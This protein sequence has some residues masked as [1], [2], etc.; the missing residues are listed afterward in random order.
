MF[1][2][3]ESKKV[4]INWMRKSSA[5]LEL[6]LDFLNFVFENC[7]LTGSVLSLQPF[8]NPSPLSTL[9]CFIS[10]VS[11]GAKQISWGKTLYWCLLVLRI[12]IFCHWDTHGSFSCPGLAYHCHKTV[13]IN[14]KCSTEYFR[15]KLNSGDEIKSVMQ[16]LFTWSVLHVLDVLLCSEILHNIIVLDDIYTF[17]FCSSQHIMRVDMQLLPSIRRV[18]IQ[19]IKQQSCHVDLLWEWLH[20]SLQAMRHQ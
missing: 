2:S 17:M 16:I 10:F 3:E 9:S 13:H 12:S 19:F 20:S 5:R 11:L 14:V 6:W 15:P 1:V 7:Q 8:L 4:G 18:P